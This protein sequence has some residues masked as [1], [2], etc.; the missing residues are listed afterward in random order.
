MSKSSL[1][2]KHNFRLVQ[3][4]SGAAKSQITNAINDHD[5]ES[6]GFVL[7]VSPMASAANLIGEMIIHKTSGQ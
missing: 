7:K 2:P 4:G 6:G 5:V 3:R 1:R